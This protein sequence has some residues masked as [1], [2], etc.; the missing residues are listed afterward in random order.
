MTMRH[1]KKFGFAVVFLCLLT[2]GF[3]IFYR[4]S[5]SPVIGRPYKL[6]RVTSVLSGSIASHTTGSLSDSTSFF[7]LV[8]PSG[9]SKQSSSN[10]QNG[11]LIFSQS[12]TRLSPTP[13]IIQIGLYSDGGSIDTNSSYELRKNSTL[14]TIQKYDSSFLTFTTNFDGVVSFIPSSKF[15]AVISVTSGLEQSGNYLNT[16]MIIA[17]DIISS[18]QWR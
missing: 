14:Y 9:F 17:K 8:L 2:F 15:V 5:S 16:E 10:Q 18:W 11:S 4:F 7:D 6:T 13:L 1:F 3:I 12:Y